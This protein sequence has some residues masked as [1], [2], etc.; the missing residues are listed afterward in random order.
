MSANDTHMHNRMTAAR[1]HPRG[2]TGLQRRD[3]NALLHW[4]SREKRL[5]NGFEALAAALR[6][7]M[8]E[9]IRTAV[10]GHDVW[11]AI[12]AVLGRCNDQATYTMPRA[13]IA[14]AWL[15]LLDRYVRTWLALEHLLRCRFLPMGRYGVH[16]LDVGT[17]PGSSAFATHD[18]YAAMEDYAQ[19]ENAADW[20]QPPH[21]TCVE[22][23]TSM[24]HIRHILAESLAIRGAPRSVIAMAGGLGDFSTI[25]PS[26]LRRQLEESLRRQYDEYY[27]EQRQEWDADP[28]YT[29]EQA[30]R[31]AS[32]HHRY[33]LFTFSNF[34]TT[35]KKIQEYKANL[36]DILADARAGSVLLMIGGKGG[37]YQAIQRHMEELAI[38]GGF[39]RLNYTVEV[40]ATTDAQLHLRLDQEVR[41]FYRHLTQLTD[42]FSPTEPDAIKLCKELNN[43]RLIRLNSSTIHAFRK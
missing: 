18:F 21:I 36:K 42:N 40:S 27:D 31:E 15:H 43:D 10:D 39:R 12:P 29:A 30:S 1:P 6:G 16:V 3:G 41:W 32:T 34:L 14:Y 4:L 19:K 13:E 24:N 2:W 22:S 26:E 20:Q 33:R 28:A 7:T 37:C 38:A 5:Q 17:G 35:T 23:E 9:Q 25:L 11:Q 8:E